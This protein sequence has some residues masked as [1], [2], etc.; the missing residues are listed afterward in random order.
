MLLFTRLLTTNLLQE[1]C[2]SI[3]KIVLATAVF[4]FAACNTLA[5]QEVE[6][7]K[8]KEP[9]TTVKKHRFFDRMLNDFYCPSY[10][11]R[12]IWNYER[13]QSMIAG[14]NPC[15]YSDKE[16][17]AMKSDLEWILNRS[18]SRYSYEE[19]ECMQ[20]GGCNRDGYSYEELESMKYEGY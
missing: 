15:G 4:G 20:L 8:K 7:L 2:V 19:L 17:Q 13:V 18:R 5:M 1:N 14:N 6:N 12:P 16:L 9:N 11:G 3:K 10:K